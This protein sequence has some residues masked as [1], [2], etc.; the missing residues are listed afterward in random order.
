MEKPVVALQLNGKS[1]DDGG[2]LLVRIGNNTLIKKTTKRH[3][4]YRIDSIPEYELS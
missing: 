2:T 1:V 4:A 3:R